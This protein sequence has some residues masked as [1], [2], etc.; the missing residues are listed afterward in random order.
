MGVGVLGGDDGSRRDENVA[1]PTYAMVAGIA[2]ASMSAGITGLGGK[3]TSSARLSAISGGSLAA[4]G[5]AVAGTTAV[6]T[7][8]LVLPVI[9]AAT[10]AVIASGG[11]ILEKQE[12]IRREIESA[13]RDFETNEVAVAQFIKRASDIREMLTVA[14]VASRNHIRTIET[15]LR[16]GDKVEFHRLSP[17]AESS[18]RRLSEILLACLTV[19]ALPIAM[20]LDQVTPTPS[21]DT[22]VAGGSSIPQLEPTLAADSEVDSA[23]IDFVINEAFGQIAR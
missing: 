13:E 18:V 16:A 8:L 2:A 5:M 11:R 12:S 7:G 1:S 14:L 3:A 20:S 22:G 17:S 15:A 9:G 19:L 23:F 6:L 10:A 4:G 21:R